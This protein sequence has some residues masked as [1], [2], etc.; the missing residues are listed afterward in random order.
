MSD[1]Q[2]L[3]RFANSEIHQNVA[4][5][6]VSVNLRFVLGKRIATISTGRVDEAGL[7]AVV[8]RAAAIARTVEELEDWAGLP[9]S[10]PRV[11]QPTGLAVRLLLGHGRGLAGTPSGGGAGRHRRRRRRRGTR[12]RV[13]FHGSRVDGGRQLGRH[14]CLRGAHEFPTPDRPHVPGRGLGLRRAG[15]HGRDEHRPGGYRPRGSRTGEGDRWR[16]LGAGRR[17]SRRPRAVRG[18]R[19]PRHAR[20]RGVLGAGRRGGSLVLRA[21]SPGGLRPR[22]DHRRRRQPGRPPDD[23]RLRG[24][25]QGTRRAH[26][27][28]ASAAT[29]STTP[30][31]RPAPADDPPDTACRHRT[32]TAR[33]R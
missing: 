10:G 33:S 21:G 24:R 18:G 26:R 13:L 5:T 27:E 19:H 3:T 11:V 15:G 9:G 2:A 4:E 28:R 32:R 7:A 1:D 6:S 16:D 30:R 14:P 8:Q 25:P 23:L 20:L 22:D 29:S 31:R 12:V 17:L